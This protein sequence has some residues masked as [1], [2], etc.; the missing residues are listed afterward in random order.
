M[1]IATAKKYPRDLA[2]VKKKMLDFA[3]LDEET[4]ESCFYTLKRKDRDSGEGK[5]I[6]GPSVRL[7]EIAVACYGN[8]RAA[9]RITDND[10]RFIT[11]QGLCHDLE[12]NT[13]I[14]I[15]AKRRITGKSGKT[16]G[17]DMQT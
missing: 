14:S 7:A 16:Y 17:D 11:A 5:V 3:T 2:K 6:Q 4:A 9:A 10:G 12:S 15:E 8:L 1:Q 13:L